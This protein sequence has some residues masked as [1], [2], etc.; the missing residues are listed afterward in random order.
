VESGAGREMAGSGNAVKASLVCVLEHGAIHIDAQ[1][2]FRNLGSFNSG[3][4]AG[5][6]TV[7]ASECYRGRGFGYHEFGSWVLS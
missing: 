4:I 2:L 3:L 5:A 7:M 1:K 6:E